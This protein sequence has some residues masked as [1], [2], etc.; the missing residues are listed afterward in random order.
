[1]ATIPKRATCGYLPGVGPF[2]VLLGR[3]AL[4]TDEQQYSDKSSTDGHGHWPRTEEAEMNG[5][6]DEVSS[7]VSALWQR[8]L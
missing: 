5:T 3:G 1:M 6:G 4:G 8:G 7:S 2:V